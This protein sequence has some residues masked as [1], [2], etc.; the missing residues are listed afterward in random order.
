LLSAR[1]HLN[2]SEGLLVQ[3]GFDTAAEQHRRLLNHQLLRSY[4]RQGKQK[5]I[6]EARL[7]GCLF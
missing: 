6:R 1:Y 7:S 5:D 4:P 3:G 2:I